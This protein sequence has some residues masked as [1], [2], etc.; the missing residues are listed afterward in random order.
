[1]CDCSCR[2]HP[3]CIFS[4]CNNCHVC[5]VILVY[6]TWSK[7]WQHLTIYL[8][9]VGLGAI[10]NTGVSGDTST[11]LDS[12]SRHSSLQ[13]ELSSTSLL[14]TSWSSGLCHCPNP[15]HSPASFWDILPQNYQYLDIRVFFQ[16][17]IPNAPHTRFKMKQISVEQLFVGF[18]KHFVLLNMIEAEGNRSCGST[19]GPL[20]SIPCLQQ[21][22]AL[23]D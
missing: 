1:M 11:H 20:G 5:E 4:S 3:K 9:F 19:H 10:I 7:S 14:K 18:W 23:L 17:H 22:G 16:L 6:L 12:I 21:R 2:I 13:S 15:P 8:K